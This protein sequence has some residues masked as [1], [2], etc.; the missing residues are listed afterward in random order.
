MH[1]LHFYLYLGDPTSFEDI[2]IS[3]DSGV[4]EIK[5]LQYSNFQGMLIDESSDNFI[6]F[7]SEKN[8]KIYFFG[9]DMGKEYKLKVNGTFCDFDGECSASQTHLNF[10]YNGT[11][12]KLLKIIGLGNQQ[13]LISFH[14]RSKS[15]RIS[16]ISIWT[17]CRIKNKWFFH[18]SETL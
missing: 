3:Y 2:T 18:L 17:R 15:D 1:W 7:E 4:A 11:H 8:F 16:R 13:H 14:F 12:S 6:K 10:I 5:H 9:L